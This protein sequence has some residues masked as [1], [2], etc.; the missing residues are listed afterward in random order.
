MPSTGHAPRHAVGR[1]RDVAVA[2]LACTAAAGGG[3]PGHTAGP[4]C[5]VALLLLLEGVVLHR[6]VR[7]VLGRAAPRSLH[8]REEVA[9]AR[10][11]ARLASPP[12]AHRNATA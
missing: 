11:L 3:G 10:V 12:R 8:A 5:I 9:D 6:L 1:L 2:V 4:A 7:H